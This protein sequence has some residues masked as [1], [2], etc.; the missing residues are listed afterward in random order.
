MT[1]KRPSS[2]SVPQDEVLSRRLSAAVK[3]CKKRQ[4]TLEERLRV[5]DQRI[6]ELSEALNHG[7]RHKAEFLSTMSHELRT[8]LNV[9]LG[10][11]SLIYDEAF[12]SL[13][14]QQQQACG[15]VLESAERLAQLVNDLLDTAKLDRG[16]LTFHVDRVDLA[17]VSRDAIEYLRPQAES[18]GLT[19]EMDLPADLPP[20]R[21]DADRMRQVIGHLLDNA[22]KFTPA[23][24]RI[25]VRGT[26][27]RADHM[28]VIEVWDTGIGI[29]IEALPR[30]FERFFQVD[31]SNTREYG[32]V[33]I[34]L[35]LVK[36]FVERL[37]G[38]VDVMSQAGRGSTFRITLPAA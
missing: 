22:L 20:V 33:G 5:Q 13:N 30:L 2:S 21:A 3:R 25:G 37:G 17:E 18:K 23:G 38:D 1:A 4:A 10:F 32:G 8:P 29:P 6:K 16:T 31:S 11:A 34:G 36:E 35:A 28:V 14:D 15:K 12:G 24:G 7:E 26:A 27:E 19:V 9:V